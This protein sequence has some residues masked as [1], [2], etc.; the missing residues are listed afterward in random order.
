MI[1]WNW[2][3]AYWCN[4][5]VFH[6]RFLDSKVWNM[7]LNAKVRGRIVGNLTSKAY[8]HDPGFDVSDHWWLLMSGSGWACCP[9]RSMCCP[10]APAAFTRPRKLL[11]TTTGRTWTRIPFRYLVASPSTHTGLHT[12]CTHSDSFGVGPNRASFIAWVNKK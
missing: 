2:K 10:P 11:Q 12:V 6:S 5:P 8:Q 3:A 9:L 1:S 7:T 4:Q